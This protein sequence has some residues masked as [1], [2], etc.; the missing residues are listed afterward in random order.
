MW[1]IHFVVVRT[2]DST[3]RP[4]TH[5]LH[6][7]IT[8]KLE[9]HQIIIYWK[10]ALLLVSFR[11]SSKIQSIFFRILIP[12]FVCAWRCLP[13][14]LYAYLFLLLLYKAVS[15]F[16]FGFRVLFHMLCILIPCY[17]RNET[18]V[19]FTIIEMWEKRK[20]IRSI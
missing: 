9:D 8:F 16:I 10:I 6:R 5:F 20:N 19:K 18:L 1:T 17:K 2:Q 3:L 14:L 11:C 12:I 15:N 4:A 13:F 7:N